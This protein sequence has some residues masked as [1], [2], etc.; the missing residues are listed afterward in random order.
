MMA[1]SVDAAQSEYEADVPMTSEDLAGLA[2]P[3]SP[4]NA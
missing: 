1:Q 2:V 4:S 3:D